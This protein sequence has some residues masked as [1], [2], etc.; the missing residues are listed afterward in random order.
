MRTALRCR[1][2]VVSQQPAEAL[3]TCNFTV[4]LADFLARLD[5]L[6]AQPLMVSFAMI[7]KKVLANSIPQRSFAEKDHSLETLGF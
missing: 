3:V 1:S 7:V 6:I 5:Q 2:V 4:S